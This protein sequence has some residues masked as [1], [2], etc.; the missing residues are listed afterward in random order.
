MLGTDKLDGLDLTSRLNNL[1][2]QPLPAIPAKADGL[3]RVADVPTYFTDAIVRRAHA[4]QQTTSA[5]EPR[6][7]LPPAVAAQLGVLEGAT[8]RVKQGT[9]SAVMACVIDKNLPANVVRVAAGHPATATLG[10]MFGAI[11]VE[12]A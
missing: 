12:K 8:V 11:S 10:A 1:V 3:Q 7:V 6:A 5:Q 9:A 2:K 4:L